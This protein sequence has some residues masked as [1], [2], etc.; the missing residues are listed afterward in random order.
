MEKNTPHCKLS[1]VHILLNMGKV[2]TTISAISGAAAL[3]LDFEDMLNV[4][5]DLTIRDFH[6]SMTTHHDQHIWQDVYKPV[7]R[8]GPVYLKL[9]VLSDVLIVSFKEL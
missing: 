2:R 3:G 7:T 4:V 9:T 1:K 6:K 8:V 5:S